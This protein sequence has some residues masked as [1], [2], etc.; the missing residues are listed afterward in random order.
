M[1]GLVASVAAL[2]LIGATFVLIG[3][4]GRCNVSEAFCRVCSADVRVRAW[5]EA[6]RCAC[7]ASLVGSGR[8]RPGKRRRSRVA[9]AGGCVML[10]AST[11]F[12][13]WVARVH[14]DGRELM[15]VVPASIV[16]WGLRSGHEWAWEAFDRRGAAMKIVPADAA[17]LLDAAMESR[18]LWTGFSRTDNAAHNF[19]ENLDDQ[20]DDGRRTLRAALDL[21]IQIESQDASPTQLQLRVDMRRALSGFVRVDS[22]RIGDRELPFSLSIRDDSV[23][24]PPGVRT[25]HGGTIVVQLPPQ[26]QDQGGF[27]AGTAIEIELTMGVAGA[28]TVAIARDPVVDGGAPRTAWGIDVLAVEERRRVVVPKRT[29]TPQSRDGPNVEPT[30]G[31]SS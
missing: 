20:S 8:I 25:F 30:K 4:I 1:F 10:T 7:G 13:M 6:P 26:L 21:T 14:T 28:A 9:L 31:F 22:M 12:A 2:T 29:S 27:A 11:A 24:F 18:P 23:A 19:L 5:D 15:D 16:A 17:V 3:L